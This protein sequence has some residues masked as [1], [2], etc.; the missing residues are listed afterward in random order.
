MSF[1]SVFK[2]SEADNASFLSQ[3]FTLTSKKYSVLHDNEQL[4]ALKIQKTFTYRLIYSL[5]RG[6]N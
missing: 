3:I 1:I 2:N 4:F 5:L 6:Y